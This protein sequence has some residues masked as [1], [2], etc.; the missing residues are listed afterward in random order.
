MT[1]NTSWI[2]G[3]HWEILTGCRK[4]RWLKALAEDGMDAAEQELRRLMEMLGPGHV[5]VSAARD[6]ESDMP[7][8]TLV[9]SAPVGERV[10]EVL[11]PEARLSGTLPW[12]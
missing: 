1:S 2:F 3:G 7:T 8:A 12:R 11:E 9:T 6:V 5:H 4:G 10:A